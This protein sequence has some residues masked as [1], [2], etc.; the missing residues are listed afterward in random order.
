MPMHYPP[1][2]DGTFRYGDPPRPLPS[3]VPGP[4]PAGPAAPPSPLQHEQFPAPRP[5]QPEQSSPPNSLH[6]GPPPPGSPPG[7][8][9]PVSETP[10]RRG[11][12]G[13]TAAAAIIGGLA[14]V[15]VAVLV[16]ALFGSDSGRGAGAPVRGPLPPQAAPAPDR[17]PGASFTAEGRF[18]VM[19]S[20][21]EPVSG[22]GSGCDLP[23]SLSDLGEGTRITLSGG[24]SST[25]GSTLLAYD[26]GD[27]S[28]CTFTFTFDEVPSGVALY[29]IEIPGRGQL[30][31][32]EDEL[33]AGI[34]ITLGR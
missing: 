1:L 13:G 9:P 24:I 10:R 14:L 20:A 7:T 8:G 34:D 16:F 23:D 27:L 5:L 33:R 26:N 3:P 32:T 30:T 15:V 21:G 12:S 25:I 6:H 29:L 19:S 22:D 4:D 28:S 2:A 18:T 11:G 31:Y 17:A